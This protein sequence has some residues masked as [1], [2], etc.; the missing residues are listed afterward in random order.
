LIL[1]FVCGDPN[2]V[3]APEKSIFISVSSFNPVF[4][5]AFHFLR[6]VF[7]LLGNAVA[8]HLFGEPFD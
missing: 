2:P 8:F 5:L 4:S 3:S 6:S 1:F 7:L